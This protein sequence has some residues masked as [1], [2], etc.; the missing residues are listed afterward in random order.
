MAM[1]IKV[2]EKKL[3]GSVLLFVCSLTVLVNSKVFASPVRVSEVSLLIAFAVIA[4]LY[5][6]VRLWKHAF[7]KV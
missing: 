7:V 2:S 6:A 1:P 3:F 5:F 4:M